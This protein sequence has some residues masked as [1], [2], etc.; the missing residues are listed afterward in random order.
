MPS[1]TSR[2]G[3]W[4][5]GGEKDTI[6]VGLGGVV[7]DR[8]VDRKTQMVVRDAVSVSRPSKSRKVDRHSSSAQQTNVNRVDESVNKYR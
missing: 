8:G 6:G 4:A 7:K 2:G 1:Q 5:R 3:W